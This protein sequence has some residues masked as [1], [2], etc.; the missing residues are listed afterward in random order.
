VPSGVGI[1]AL[2]ASSVA[3]RTREIGIRIALGSTMSRAIRHLAAIGI[4]P[5][6]VGLLLGLAACAGVLR[7]MRSVLYGVQIYDVA[8]LIAVVGMLTVIAVLAATMPALRIAGIDP[9]KTLR[10]E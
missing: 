6:V 7:I 3:Q 1:F 8:N 10:Q 9:A 5:V 2:V 4:R